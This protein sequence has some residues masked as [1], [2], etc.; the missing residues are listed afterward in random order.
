VSIIQKTILLLQPQQTAPHG[1]SNQMDVMKEY[2]V[3][4]A[5]D[6][7]GVKDA[8]LTKVASVLPIK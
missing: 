1:I 7:T 4:T 8:V 2:A 6:S 3:V 5:M